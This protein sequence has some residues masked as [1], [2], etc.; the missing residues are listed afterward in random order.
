[1]SFIN[2]NTQIATHASVTTNVHGT[3]VGNDVASDNDISG[4]RENIVLNAFRIAVNGSL[5]LFN[6]HDGTIDDFKDSSGILTDTTV[7]SGNILQPWVFNEIVFIAATNSDSDNPGEVL[8]A[9]TDN[10][11]VVRSILGTPTGWW[12]FN[13]DSAKIVKRYKISCYTATSRAPKNW[14]LKGSA[15]GAFGGEETLLD[16]Q[17]NQVFSASETKTYTCDGFNSFQYYKI[18]VTLNNGD[19]T[20]TELAELE[21]YECVTPVISNSITAESQPYSVHVVMSVDD[22]AIALNTDFKFYVSVDNGGT[23]EQ[24]TL[25]DIGEYSAT[26]NIFT[27]SVIIAGTGTTMKYKI[28]STNI[29]FEIYAVGLLWA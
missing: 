9:L 18:D 15:T 13:F 28:E 24:I 29:L 1:M 26:S 27:G 22:A 4:F 20:I 8:S 17:T 3:G 14:T 19:D 12:K 2:A 11:L 6:L 25:E 5:A 7:I 10:N 23:W 16:T 21:T